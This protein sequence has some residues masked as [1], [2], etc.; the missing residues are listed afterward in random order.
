MQALD[1]GPLERQGAGALQ[2]RTVTPTHWRK[3]NTAKWDI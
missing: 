2:M 1:K 3:Q